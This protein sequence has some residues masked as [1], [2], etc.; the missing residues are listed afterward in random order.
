M[1]PVT[2]RSSSRASLA[3]PSALSKRSGWSPITASYSSWRMRQVLAPP[4]SLPPPPASGLGQSQPRWQAFPVQGTGEK[5]ALE[6]AAGQHLCAVVKSPERA[7]PRPRSRDSRL[8]GAAG[9]PLNSRSTHHPD[10]PAQPGL[11]GTGSAASSVSSL[12]HWLRL[13]SPAAVTAACRG[14]CSRTRSHQYCGAGQAQPQAACWAPRRLSVPP[15]FPRVSSCAWPSG[16]GSWC[17]TMTSALAWR[18]RNPAATPP[19][20]SAA[21]PTKR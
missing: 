15:A 7:G 2:P 20:P 14:T 6:M 21:P 8:S 18:W 11:P 17:S 4:R 12:G 16:M 5:R 10:P 3:Q 13:E 19:S 9:A 1:A